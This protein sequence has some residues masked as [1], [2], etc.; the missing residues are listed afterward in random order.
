MRPT[1]SA[2]DMGSLFPPT[3]RMALRFIAVTTDP[4]LFT[5]ILHRTPCS[6]P[7]DASLDASQEP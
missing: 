1:R 3:G 6:I 7:P 5:L 2:I 4:R